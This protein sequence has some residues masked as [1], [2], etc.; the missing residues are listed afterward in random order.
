MSAG[1]ARMHV[2]CVR[3]GVPCSS[4]RFHDLVDVSVTVCYHQVF[5]ACVCVCVVEM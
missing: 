5:L 1:V 4:N 2:A 3:D